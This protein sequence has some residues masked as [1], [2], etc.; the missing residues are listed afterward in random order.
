M[1]VDDNRYYFHIGEWLSYHPI[2]IGQEVNYEVKENEAR[3]IKI[4]IPKIKEYSIHLKI[5][6]LV[7]VY[8]NH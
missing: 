2:K 6:F 3:N 4:C 1:G 5:N 8:K 7:G